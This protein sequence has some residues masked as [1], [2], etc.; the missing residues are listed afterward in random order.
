MTRASQVNRPN[1]V[2][3]GWRATIKQDILNII[4]DNYSSANE[5]LNLLG[6]KYKRHVNTHVV[7]IYLMHMYHEGTLDR[8]TDYYKKNKKHFRRHIYKKK[9]RGELE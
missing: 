3:K 7:G 9:T 4:P 8:T 6:P 1:E 5:I 2:T